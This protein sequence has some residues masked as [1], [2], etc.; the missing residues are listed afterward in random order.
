M[1]LFAGFA[2]MSIYIETMLIPSLP[3]I[4]QQYHVN[5]AETS[6]IV[7]LYLVSGVALNP[8][9]G[10]LGDVYGKKKVLTYILPIYVIAVGVTGFAPNFTF[11]LLSRTIQG[12]GLTA[13]PLLISLIQEEFPKDM[14]PRAIATIVAMFGVGSAIGLPLGSFISNS[15][16]WQVTYHSAFPFVLIVAALIIMKVKESRYT[17]PNV[18]VDYIGAV[19]LAVSLAAIVFALSEGTAYGWASNLIILLFAIGIVFFAGLLLYEKRATEPI[20][21]QK[22]LGIK[23]VLCSNFLVLLAG[24]AMFFS[25]QVFAYLFESPAPLGLGYDIFHTGLALLPFAVFNVIVAPFAGR[26]IPR[27]GVK[28]FFMYGAILAMIGFALAAFGSGAMLTIVGEAI[29]GA[30][31]ALVN[32]PTVNL[33]VLSIAQRDMGLATS[34]NSVFRFTGSALGAPVAGLLIAT[35]ESRVAFQDAFYLGIVSMI[36]VIIIAS[37]ADEILGKNKKITKL[38]EE[39]SI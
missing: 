21:N 25:Y 36:F 11:L 5:A 23:N 9:I 34:L 13:F 14:V 2:I 8:I 6:L 35:Y 15:F 4:G 33:L 1:Y 39:V 32:I 28:P 17:R 18:K 31:L 20:L 30:G 16:G 19:L 22:L 3:S 27:L 24:L 7:S 37:Q 26:Y 29:I 12:I 38:E 10:K